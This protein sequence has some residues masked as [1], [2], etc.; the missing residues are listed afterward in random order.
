MDEAWHLGHQDGNKH[1]HRGPEHVLCNVRTNA[2]ERHME[3]PK[4][5]VD[6]WW[7]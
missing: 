7:E 1:V 6:K 5:R 2:R 3:D 4:P